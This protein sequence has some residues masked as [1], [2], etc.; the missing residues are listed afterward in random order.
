MPMKKDQLQRNGEQR[1]FGGKISTIV[2][3]LLVVAMVAT[4]ALLVWQKSTSPLDR[5]DYE[6]TIV[7]RWADYAESS[8][9]SRPRLGLLVESNDG[10]RFTVKVDPNVYESARV[11]MRIKSKAGQ[12]VL[13]DA[14]RSSTGGK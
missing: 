6:G 14:E 1:L 13:I 3:S 10:K 7:D 4:L 2:I 9:G 11:G 8:Q 12:V 5:G